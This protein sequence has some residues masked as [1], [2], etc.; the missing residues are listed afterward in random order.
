MAFYTYTFYRK[1]IS[2]LTAFC[3]HSIE[4]FQFTVGAT[5]SFTRNPTMN[6]WAQSQMLSS[7][8]FYLQFFIHLFD[9]RPRPKR[10]QPNAGKDRTD[11]KYFLTE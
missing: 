10:D 6:R 7:K 3:E 8:P 2:I 1:K 11:Q 4:V 5:K 9:E